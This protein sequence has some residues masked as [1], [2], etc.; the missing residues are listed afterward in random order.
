LKLFTKRREKRFYKNYK[1]KL[2]A[3]LTER[4]K[5]FYKTLPTIKFYDL[6]SREDVS[7]YIRIL[8]KECEKN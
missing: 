7:K 2:K 3:E 6:V 1:E 5:R 4:A 8:I